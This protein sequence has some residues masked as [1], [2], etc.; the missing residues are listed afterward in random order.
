[1]NQEEEILRENIRHL[2]KYV[3]QKKLNDE[4]EVRNSLK[5]LMR[6]EL[7]QMLAEEA[8]P[9]QDP[10]PNKSTGI[11][12]L[13]DLLKKIIPIE[14]DD[15]R[16]MTT[17]P[18]QR[19]SFRAHIIKAIQDTL[20]AVDASLDAGET[21]ALAEDIEIEVGQDEDLNKFIDIRTPQEKEKEEGPEDPADPREEFGKGLEALDATGRNM[22]YNTF[23]KIEKN[24]IDSYDLL[25][26]PDD[27]ELF[28]DY[29]IAN[30]KLYFDKFEDQLAV[31]VEEPTN[32]AYETAKEQEP[33]DEATT[34]EP[35]EIFEI[36][37]D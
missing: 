28:Y 35:E 13:A 24:I 7:K 14:K 37:L 16:Q 12:V 9:D 6:L 34:T 2:I 23:K 8:I 11:N 29:L 18:S 15:F 4:Q 31:N 26:N 36:I 3:K 33:G 20:I 32:Q 10:A 22:A 1:M 25:D 19:K 30:T 27:Q 17:D 5:E 21:T